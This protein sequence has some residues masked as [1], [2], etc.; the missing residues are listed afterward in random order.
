MRHRP[1]ASIR[2]V[3]QSSPG[4]SLTFTA[5]ADITT[6]TIQWQA[7]ANGGSS[8]INVSG[9][10][11]PTFTATNLAGFENGWELRAVFTNYVGSATSA[12]ATITVTAPT[13]TVVLPSNNATSSGNQYLDAGAS[14]GVTKVQYEVTGGSLTNAVIATATPT[15]YGW[16]ATWNTTTVPNGTYT[17]QSVA[18][19]GGLTGTSPG[20]TVTVNNANPTT[21]VVLPSNNAMLSGNQYLD[22]GASPGVTKVQYELSGGSLSNAVIATATPTIYG[23]LAAW[24]T[25]TVLN[26]T[27]TL[28]SVASYAGGVSGT[29]APITVSVSN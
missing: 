6:P 7:S 22:A 17:L 21:T 4:G 18:T 12:P 11:N 1:S 25:T 5:A 27:Y 9:A 10:T 24:N 16:L 14:P 23:W 28:Q 3:N 13:T 29:S 2:R 26:G 19:S 15:I 20:V 8:W